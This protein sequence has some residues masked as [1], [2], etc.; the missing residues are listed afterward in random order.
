MNDSV[1]EAQLKF[2]EVQ[3][4]TD[5]YWSL[6]NEVTHLQ[7]DGLNYQQAEFVVAIIP[8]DQ[9]EN[10]LVWHE[11][12]ANWI[13]LLESKELTGQKPT[14]R[15]APPLPPQRESQ[16]LS[17]SDAGGRAQM[18]IDNRL[19]RR[20]VKKFSVEIFG[21]SGSFKTTTINVSLGG[22]RLQDPIPAIVGNKFNVLLH[23]CPV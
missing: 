17:A 23:C 8:N 18:K 13:P 11:G 20:F 3:N 16:E 15:R 4:P 19:N 7:A 12:L 9:K 2:Q 6:V 10:W 1:E 5:A 21:M 14:G 22:M